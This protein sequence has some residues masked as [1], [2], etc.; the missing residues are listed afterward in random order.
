MELDDATILIDA[1]WVGNG[2]PGRVV[3]NLLRGL[4]EVEPAGSWILWGSD[5]AAEFGWSGSRHLHSAHSPKA[6]LG[7]REI[8]KLPKQVDLAYFPHQIRPAWR[9]AHREITT[10]HDT[11]P[12]RYSSSRGAAMS[13]KLYF[14][15]MA[16]LSTHI[17]TDSEFSKR[18]LIRDLKVAPEKVSVLALPIDHESADRVRNLR[19]TSRTDELTPLVVFLGRDAPHKNLDRLVRAFAKTEAQSKGATLLLIGVGSEAAERLTGL[20]QHCGARLE[21]PGELSQSDLE[22]TLGRASLLVQPSFEEGF[23]LPVAEALA[24]G[25]P[26]A[27]SS[28]GSLPEIT[29]NQLRG[30][31]PNSEAEITEAIDE[32]LTSPSLPAIQFLRP[33]EFAENFLGLA[34]RILA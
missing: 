34:S 22:A 8:P 25:I 17:A 26:V 16:Q 21:T 31:D 9:L 1:R 3:E 23:G 18:C 28:G 20:A 12:F 5:K 19:D 4:R 30:F 2:G 27:I 15:W 13:L 14:R 6:L 29:Q 10:I 24:A 33:A 11:I 7:Q 32:G